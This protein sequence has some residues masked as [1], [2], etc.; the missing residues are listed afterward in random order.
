[1][2]PSDQVHLYWLDESLIF[3]W[4]GNALKEPNGL[5]A[6]GGDLSVERL[7]LAYRNGIFPW[8]SPGEPI[9]WWSPDPRLVLLPEKVHIS[10]SLLKHIRQIQQQPEC[11]IVMNTGFREVIT[12]C[13]EVNRPDQYGTWIT[14]E[15][16]QAYCD[17][18][19]AGYAHSVEFWR[20]EQL[21]GGLYGIAID[22]VF[23][24]ESMFSLEPNASKLCLVA[25]GQ[26]LCQEGFRLIDCQ[27]KTEHL[28]TMGANEM[29]RSE[30]LAE[31]E[32]YGN[33]AFKTCH[34]CNLQQIVRARFQTQRPASVSPTL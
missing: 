29:P 15:M 18:H 2:S 7:L 32:L 21:M 22:R 27:V 3:P 23:F 10:K 12:R 4:P 34:L 13:A 24:G 19:L 28:V 25:L 11:R 9:L 5:L 20:G 6:A 1:M 14:E 8:Y 17:F 33:K 16:L 26:L 31:L 30:F